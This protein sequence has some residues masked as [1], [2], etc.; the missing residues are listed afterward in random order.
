MN[1]IERAKSEQRLI[2]LNTPSANL[3]PI[4]DVVNEIIPENTKK[5]NL[6]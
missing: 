3:F 4:L 1:A 5:M 6:K 2:N